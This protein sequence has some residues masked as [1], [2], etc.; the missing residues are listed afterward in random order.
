MLIKDAWRK[1][2]KFRLYVRNKIDIIYYVNLIFQV[3]FSLISLTV[4][5]FE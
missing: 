3:Y 4:P 5:S 2:L 1:I